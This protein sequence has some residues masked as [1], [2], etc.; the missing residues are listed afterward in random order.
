MVWLM[1][2][3]RA[4]SPVSKHSLISLGRDSYTSTGSS[5]PG[6]RRSSFGMSYMALIKGTD[7]YSMSSSVLSN[8]FLYTFLPST[9][10]CRAASSSAFLRSSSS[11]CFFTTAL[12]CTFLQ[13]SAAS[14]SKYSL[15]A[16]F[17]SILAKN[18][19]TKSRGGLSKDFA[20]AK[21]WLTIWLL[22][23]TRSMAL[24]LPFISSSRHFRRRNALQCSVTKT[25]PCWTRSLW[26]AS[27]SALQNSSSSSS[28]FW[29]KV[30]YSSTSQLTSPFSRV[31]R[32]PLV[33]PSS[34]SP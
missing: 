13:N 2:W 8:V 34:P 15:A 1:A 9:S 29:V 6:P 5:P 4:Q 25:P 24:R 28:F 16:S 30:L 10:A 20:S 7:S 18:W 14:W 21:I 19:C 27:Q 3:S 12:S 23:P 11:S 26:A 22:S 32:N 17:S 31:S 33:F